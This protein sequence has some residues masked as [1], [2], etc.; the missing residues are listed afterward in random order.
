MLLYRQILS[1]LK[2]QA[3]PMKEDKSYIC[4]ATASMIIHVQ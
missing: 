4:I 1:T 2:I 3:T